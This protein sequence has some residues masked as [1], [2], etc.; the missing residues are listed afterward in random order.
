[1][2]KGWIAPISLVVSDIVFIIYRIIY[3]KIIYIL[4]IL[5]QENKRGGAS[6]GKFTS[7][8]SP[9]AGMACARVVLLDRSWIIGR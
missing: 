3:Y 7:V 4:Y 5:E 8:P 1:M 2:G 6:K 9:A